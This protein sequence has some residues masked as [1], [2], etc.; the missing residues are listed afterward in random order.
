MIISAANP[1]GAVPTVKFPDPDARVTTACAA[2]ASPA[3]R[4]S[5]TASRGSPASAENASRGRFN[6]S[7]SA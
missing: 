6:E 1:A 3:R 2:S 5:T 7:V 4:A